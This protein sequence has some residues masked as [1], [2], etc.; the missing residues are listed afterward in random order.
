MSMFSSMQKDQVTVKSRDSGHSAM[1]MINIGSEG[2][3]HIATIFDENFIGEEGSILIR[4]LPN[5]REEAYLIEEVHYS[6][7]HGPIPPFWK[8]K[9]KK[10]TS[11][12]QMKEELQE[13]K[14]KQAPVININNSQ[15]IQIGDHNV[16]H[17]A[18]GLQGLIEKIDQSSASPQE[19]LEARGLVARL[20]ENPTVAS[21]LGGA[22]SGAIGLLK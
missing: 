15:G 4:V 13:L 6:P 12:S 8:L 5:G 22:I 19:K 2:A 14:M 18:S 1:Y 16:Q 20:L 17:I 7:G 11:F 21:L 3:H 10:G 9:L